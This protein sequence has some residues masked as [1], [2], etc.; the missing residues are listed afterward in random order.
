MFQQSQ[1]NSNP[2]AAHPATPSP[3]PPPGDAIYR[4]IQEINEAVHQS[5]TWLSPLRREVG[6][7]II[8]QEHLV[9]RLLVGILSYNFV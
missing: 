2:M 7:M 5:S 3:A 9:E 4:S 6:K 1:P 8:G